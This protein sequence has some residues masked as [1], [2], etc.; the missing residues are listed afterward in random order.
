MHCGRDA[1]S[2]P[3]WPRGATHSPWPSRSGAHSPPAG[4]LR[5]REANV[6]TGGQFRCAVL[7]AVKHDYIARGI[8]AH[9]RFELVV[10]TDD[11]HVPEWA[12]ERNQRF[13]DAHGVPYVRDVDRALRD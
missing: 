5:W 12:H 10:V 3:G 13:A 6:G 8:A 1:T 4:Q 11:P 2:R 9:P 7:S